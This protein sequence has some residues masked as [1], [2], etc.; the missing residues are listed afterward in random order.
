MPRKER[1]N[2]VDYKEMGRRV[3]KAR[4][5]KGFELSKDFAETIGYEAKT[6][7]SLESGSV[8]WSL[9]FAIILHRTL[10]I[11]YDY[12]LTGVVGGDS[13]GQRCREIVDRILVEG[14]ERD[15]EGLYKLLSEYERLL[16][17]NN[18]KN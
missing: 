14:T 7:S 6:Y 18:D 3:K 16:F 8:P 15:E 1:L 10:D 17:R 9:D 4:K 13:E 12:L 5:E 2:D 11:D